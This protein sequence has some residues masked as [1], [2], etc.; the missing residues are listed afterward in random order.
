MSRSLPLQVRVKCHNIRKEDPNPNPGHSAPAPFPYLPD[1]AE[2]IPPRSAAVLQALQQQVK[3][4]VRYLQDS[5]GMFNRLADAVCQD[6]AQYSQ[7]MQSDGCWN[8][9]TVGR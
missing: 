9:V 3:A 2:A 7:D 1:V 4:L 5:R 8:G 6:Q